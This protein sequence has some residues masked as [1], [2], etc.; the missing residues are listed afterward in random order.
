M[1]DQAA[2]IEEA[3][4]RIKT[5]G[6]FQG[7]HLLDAYHVMTNL[8]V[9]YAHMHIMRKLYLAADNLEYYSIY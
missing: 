8:K 1:S 4:K 7:H 5:K 2:G 6:V 9:T 3:V